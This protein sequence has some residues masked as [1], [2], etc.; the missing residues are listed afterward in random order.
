LIVIRIS[1]LSFSSR[2][3]LST[4]AV[5]SGAVEG[6]EEVGRGGVCVAIRV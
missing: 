6:E 4:M 3:R 2:I 5:K 1:V